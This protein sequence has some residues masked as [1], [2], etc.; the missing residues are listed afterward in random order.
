MRRINF[1]RISAFSVRIL[2]ME[3]CSAASRFCHFSLLRRADK[4][5]QQSFSS[6][7]DPEH[8][9]LG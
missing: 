9:N 6:L 3:A 5:L 2:F 8:T 1:Q 4:F 7:L